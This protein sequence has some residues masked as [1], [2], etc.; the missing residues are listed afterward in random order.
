VAISGTMPLTEKGLADALSAGAKVGVAS[1]PF[2]LIVS[3]AGQTLSIFNHSS[4]SWILDGTLRCST[5]R[6]GIG[7]IEGSNQTPL[8]LHRISEK[9]G[10]GA[11]AAPRAEA[12]MMV[13]NPMTAKVPLRK[14]RR[15]VL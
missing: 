2:V 13:G 4:G 12:G 1:S 8:G 11:P 6:F 9:I 10:G 14:P 5:S 15:L 7:Q 3:I